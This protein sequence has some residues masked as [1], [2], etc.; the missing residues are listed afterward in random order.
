MELPRPQP[1]GKLNG[2]T[3]PFGVD[4]L[5]DPGLGV[6]IIDSSQMEEVVDLADQLLLHLDRPPQQRLRHVTKNRDCA[7]FIHIPECK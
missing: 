1:L 7:R 4:L 6:E 5:L 2:L 3:G